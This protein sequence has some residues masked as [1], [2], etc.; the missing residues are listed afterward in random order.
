MLNFYQHLPEKINPL[1]FN[2]DFFSLRWYSLMFLFALLMV[3]FFLKKQIFFQEKNKKNIDW[4]IFFIYMAIGILLGGRLGYVF[5]YD[6][7]YYLHHWQEIFWPFFY[8]QNQQKLI[9]QGIS[10]MSYHGGLIGALIM[11]I[12]FCYHYKID[13]LWLADQIALVTPLGYFW[14]RIGNF[15]NGELYGRPTQKFWGMYFKGE[16]FL[17][18]PSQLYEALGEGILLFFILFFIKNR[19]WQKRKR[20]K[21][22][23][24]CTQKGYLFLSY[25]LFYNLIR[26]GIEFFRQPDEQ[27]GLIW[28]ILTLGQILSLFFIIFAILL[29]FF[30]FNFDNNKDKKEK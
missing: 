23:S 26:F 25:I 9:W 10:G 11:G 6:L 22:S 16:N 30:F 2:F 20:E 8:D 19:C 13:F 24:F 12:I 17:R 15:L 28:N 1:I 27:I 18:H 4:D 14:G 21:N 29:F 3:Y 5:F 7:S